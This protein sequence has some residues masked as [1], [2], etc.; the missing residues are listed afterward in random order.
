MKRISI[1]LAAFIFIFTLGCD[2]DRFAELNTDPSTI[3]EPDLRFSI[4]KAIEQMHENEYSMWFYSNFQQV[5]PWSQLVS[6][7]RGGNGMQ[8]NEGKDP[9]RQQIYKDL[10]RQTRDVQHRVDAMNTE[11]KAYNEVLKA[12]TYPIQIQPAIVN[13]DNS[14]SIVY[15]EA[16]YAPFTNPP[17]VTPVYDSQLVL[18][19]TWLKELDYAIGVL[20]NS[21][22]SVK[23]GN[24]DLVYE[25]DYKKWVK[26]SNLLKLKIAARLVNQDRALALKIA[27]EVGQSSDNYM[28]SISDDF[29]YN[30]GNKYFGSPNDFWIGF[31]GKNLTDFLVRNKDPRLRFTFEKNQFNAEVVQDFIDRKVALPPYVEQ[32]V[33][34]DAEGNFAGWKGPGEPWVR[35]H[36]VPL[37]PEARETAENRIYFDQAELFKLKDDNVQKSYDG[38]SSYNK[39]LAHTSKRFVYPTKLKGNVIELKPNLAPLHIILGSAGETYLY[40][41]E[42]KLLGANLP[43]TAQEYFNKGVEM[44]VLRADALAK[45]NGFPYY[46]GDPVYSTADEKI[47]GAIKLRDGEIEQ[48]LAQDAFNLDVDGLEKVYIQQYVNFMNTPGDM[49]TLVRRSGIPQRNSKYFAWEKFLSGGSELPIP[50]RAVVLTATEDSENYAN[51]LKAIQDQNFSAGKIDGAT[52]NAERLWFDKNN[53]KYGEGPKN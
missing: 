20:S 52:L 34:Y 32:Y 4:S 15:T 2:K 30:R 49:W 33:D 17:L 5:F 37:A 13:S 11:E 35:Y 41:A 48:L 8:F 21:E 23:L 26:F 14:G 1:F 6:A 40:L 16:A 47:S 53:P 29:I 44:S 42:F 36:G 12:I 18:Y 27:E 38:T 51:E 3:D 10:F 28:T 9:Q 39:Q 50:R 31:A 43:K 22:S 25:G 45:N 24:E 19:T 46:E 7:A